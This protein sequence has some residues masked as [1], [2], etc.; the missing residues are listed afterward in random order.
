MWLRALGLALFLIGF[1]FAA[2]APA[3]AQKIPPKADPPPPPPP[4]P[5]KPPK[6][7]TPPKPPKSPTPPKNPRPYTPRQPAPPDPGAHLHDGF[8]LNVS[9]GGAYIQDIVTDDAG[10]ELKMLGLGPMAGMSIGYALVTNLILHAD[11][12]G[13]F[14]GDPCVFLDDVEVERPGSRVQIGFLGGGLSWYFWNHSSGS[15]YISASA[16]GAIL[17]YDL[18]GEPEKTGVGFATTFALGHEWWIADNWAIGLVARGIYAISPGKY[19]DEHDTL[20]AGLLV[21]L[22]FN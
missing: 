22:S 13:A 16:G 7:P 9:G 6:P 14:L 17:A 3:V 4:K 15:M 19:V 10:Q 1:A 8:Y 2:P 18:S 11:A 20:A 12:Y 21:S 5:P